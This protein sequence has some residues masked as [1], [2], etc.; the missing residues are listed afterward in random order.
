MVFFVA[1]PFVMAE[2]LTLRIKFLKNVMVYVYLHLFELEFKPPYKMVKFVWYKG[3][4]AVN[5]CM[6]I[7]LK[8]L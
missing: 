8:L 5:K 4:G 7:V 6:V 3:L 2:N 1:H